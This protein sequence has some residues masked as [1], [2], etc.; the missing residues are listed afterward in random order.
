MN[1]QME[2]VQPDLPKLIPKDP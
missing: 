2:P 1:F